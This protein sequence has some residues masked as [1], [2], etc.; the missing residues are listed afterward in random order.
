LEAFALDDELHKSIERE[1]E[2]A[3]PEAHLVRKYR[4]YARGNQP[5]KLTPAE[6]ECVAGILGNR[7]CDN[8]VGKVLST[9]STRLRFSRWTFDA[10]S[11]AATKS[12]LDALTTVRQ[13]NNLLGLAHQV[14]WSMLRDGDCALMVSWKNGE[15]AKLGRAVLTREPFWDGQT[16]VFIAYDTD[17]QI[18]YA[19]KD[20]YET[21]GDLR[22]NLYY[23]DRIYKYLKA[24]SSESWEPHYDQFD[25]VNLPDG[26]A[27]FEPVWPIP[28]LDASSQPI[29][30]PFVHFANPL[31]PNDGEVADDD[32][33]LLTFSK[34]ATEQSHAKASAFFNPSYGV[35][36]CAS[37]LLGQ[38]DHLNAT[39][40]DIAGARRFTAFQMYYATGVDGT[41]EVTQ[42]DGT[43]KE[44]PIKIRVQ[45]GAFHTFTAPDSSVGTL[46]A[47]ELT[48]LI[49]SV[50]VT[51]R[52]VSR[53]SDVPMHTF[54][55]QWPSGSAI[56]Q[57]EAPL[58]FK[59][60]KIADAISS[61]WG[62]VGFWCLKLDNIFGTGRWDVERMVGTEFGSVA[63]LDPITLADYANAIAEHI[64]E[65]EY[66][67]L[68]G[69]DEGEISTIQTQRA[70]D[71]EEQQAHADALAQAALTRFNRGAGGGPQPAPPNPPTPTGG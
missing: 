57:S 41:E 32:G 29:G 54:T 42:P 47:A 10:G 35:S 69:Y 16:G 2:A 52:A 66:L 34:S 12:A 59:V 25:T 9:V 50:E 51:L 27:T 22:R 46:P 63:R 48:P 37:G 17:G 26:T 5:I 4:A 55:G 23:P 62:S 7:F 6:R 49:E 70:G 39:H 44:V 8:I 64:S 43:T 1:R 71:L 61:A 13:K 60:E 15:G 36:E 53:G 28:W 67:R 20:W 31:F 24:S 11:E 68:V 14:H 45:P 38:Q 65:A 19:V 30:V 58:N 18:S 21:N 56:Y 3:L 33:E 40:F